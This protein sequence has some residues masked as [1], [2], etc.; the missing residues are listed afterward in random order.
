VPEHDPAFTTPRFTIVSA[1]YNVGSYLEE[2]I[3]SIESQDY[4]L[5]LVEVVMVDDG[6]TD[7]SSQILAAWQARRPRLVTV[8]TKENGGQGSA[9]NAGLRHAHGEWLT[10]PD[11]DD[12]LAPNYLSEV[13]AFLNREPEVGMVATKR[14]IFEEANDRLVPHALQKHF[15]GTNRVRNLDQHPEFFHGG[16]HAA[17]FRRKVVLAEALEFDERIR[18]NFEDGHFCVSYL[19]RLERP[20]VA[21][22]STAEYT[23]RKRADRNSTLDTSRADPGRYTT[24]LQRGYVDALRQAH[25]RRGTVP[26][27]LQSF[28]LY[29]LSWYFQDD[30]AVGHGATAAYGEVADEFHRLLAEVVTYL[31]PGVIRTF[32]VRRF[33]LAWREVLL[34]SYNAEPWHSDFALVQKIDTGR[35][36]VR[37]T[38]RHTHTRPEE[39]FL[40]NG[41][42]VEPTFAKTRSVVHFDRPVLFERIVWLP[43]GAIRVKLDG[44]D[45]D[46]RLQEPERPRHTLP[47]GH[48]RDALVPRL[49]TRRRERARAA[50]RRQP[51]KPSER[52]L[53]R[54]AG[55]KLVRRAFANAWVLMDRME[56]ADD[57]AELLFRHLR[58]RRRRVNAWFVIRK[59]T[60]DHRRLRADGYK[61]VI[62]YGSIRWK[63]L[64]LNCRHL[65]SSHADPAILQPPA[66]TRLAPPGWQFCFLQH[67]VTK[68]DLSRSL[69]P[70]DIDLLITNTRAEHESFVADGS[71]YRFTERETTLAGMPRFDALLKAGELVPPDR[72]DLI[73]LAPTWRHWSTTTRSSTERSTVS[74]AE[75]VESDFGVNWL[76][77]I[78]S[79]QLRALAER[80][81]LRVA[82]LLPPD[83]QPLAAQLELPAHVE[84][85]GMEHQD[86]RARFAR[87]RVLVTDYSSMAFDAAYID[88]PV[89]YFQF[90]RDRVLSG[91]WH[92]GHR[93]YFDY[94]R[95]GYG[96]VATSL[97]D[98]LAAITDTVEFGPSPRPEYVARIAEAFPER[99][100]RCAERV[101]Q[102]I[103]A[104][105]RV[106]PRIESVASTFQE[107]VISSPR[108][109]S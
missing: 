52:L 81:R 43:S 44:S 66:V 5:D 4:P 103:R 71:P 65:V 24:V 1:V 32:G 75:F 87:A 45:V 12:T 41:V 9:R 14:T 2:F 60:P 102:A 26:D 73:L 107:T 97:E 104:S 22:V 88:R 105:T 27:W 106:A 80:Q 78:G 67:G 79:E 63:L 64:M 11:A 38:Y 83:L 82:L 76:G 19:L 61:R 62:P 25:E 49:V 23:Y 17:F 42:A 39:R 89:A 21:F 29:E 98:V 94:E 86:V 58:A 59:G 28:I 54:F 70:R 48:I 35:R 108:A 109:I 50:A 15:A 69:N 77:L 55:S 6:S 40:S 68:D 16:A 51:L 10:F 18:P 37:V 56:D 13:D 57:S 31:D 74:P 47:L 99:D 36:L 3:A 91:G 92:L 93:G 100:G 84:V 34:H 53:V 33:E 101:F 95:D 72:R 96:P 46:V 85:L 20:T 90:D 7:S 8:V 30:D